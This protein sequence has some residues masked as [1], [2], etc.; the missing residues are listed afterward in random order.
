V[1]TVFATQIRRNVEAYI[2]DMLVKS[3]TKKG[4]TDD[5][6]ETFDTMRRVGIK[7]NPK[8]NFFGLV[9]GKFLGFVVSKRGIVIH[10]SKSKAILDTAPPKN[11]KEL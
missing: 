7:L 8:K 6:A 4:H 1:N 3:M 9:G 5:H 2:D 11:L 10:P